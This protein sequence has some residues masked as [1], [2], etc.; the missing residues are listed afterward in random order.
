[1]FSIGLGLIATFNL[2]G[3]KN[4]FYI[5]KIRANIQHMSKLFITYFLVTTVC[6]ILNNMY[7]QLQ[8]L[9]IISLW[10]ISIRFNLNIFNNIVILCSIIYFTFNF[11]SIQTLN[12]DIFDKI[13]EE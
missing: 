9:I 7:N 8:D 1:M 5:K 3:I 2:N 6:F 13:N 4:K 11:Q 12:N 10:E